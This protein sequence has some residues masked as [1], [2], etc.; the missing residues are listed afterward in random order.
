VVIIKKFQRELKYKQKLLEQDLYIK[1][2]QRIRVVRR[3][4]LKLEQRKFR[5]WMADQSHLDFIEEDSYESSISI[6]QEKKKLQDLEGEYVMW[7][8]K[9]ITEMGYSKQI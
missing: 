4:K 7:D 5:S 2:H 1:R 8:Y 3:N 9:R 6:D